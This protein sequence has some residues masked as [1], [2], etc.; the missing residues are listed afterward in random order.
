M[1]KVY[2]PVSFKLIESGFPGG[3]KQRAKC[4]VFWRL[5]QYLVTGRK[6]RSGSGYNKWRLCSVFFCDIDDIMLVILARWLSTPIHFWH[7]SNRILKSGCRWKTEVRILT[8]SKMT[9]PRQLRRAA[10]RTRRQDDAIAK[11]GVSV[12]MALTFV[13]VSVR[14]KNC[15]WSFTH[16]INANDLHPQSEI[17]LSFWVAP[18]NKKTPKKQISN[19]S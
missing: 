7:V 15:V 5:V 1:W 16:F 8:A 9:F 3:C 10:Q 13:I 14:K 6:Q 12:N 17:S 2:Q 4:A 19:S 18:E 11:F